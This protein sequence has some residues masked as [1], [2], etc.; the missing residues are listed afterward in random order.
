MLKLSEKACLKAI[1]KG[2]LFHAVIEGAFEIK[3]EDYSFFVC[4]AIHDGHQLR[5]ILAK[6]CVLSESER[7]YEENPFTGEMI[8][9]MPITLIGLDSRYEYDL[10]RPPESSV[11]KKSKQAWAQPLAENEI[12]INLNKHA[13]FYRVLGAVIK[14]VEKLHGN[15]L[16]YDLHSYN[17]VDMACE[18]A[19][20][21]FNIGTEQ[22]DSIRWSQVI[23]HWDKS[24]GMADM[25]NIETRSVI[26]ELF[27]G[28]GYLATFV[29][30]NFKN[31]LVLPTKVKKVFMNELSGEP[32]PLV[33]D[34][35]KSALKQIILANALYFAKQGKP[36]IITIRPTFLIAS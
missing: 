36:K 8:S 31:T 13:L 1:K 5:E 17:Y 21:T 10:N 12:Q 35:L 24:L 20:P 26:D 28:R 15:C 34:E 22:L 2:Q 4:T 18:T 29:K 25:P 33:L 9:S 23:K 30:Q 27:F 19:P 6:N 16:V 32:Y 11:D 14:K 7:L 3:I